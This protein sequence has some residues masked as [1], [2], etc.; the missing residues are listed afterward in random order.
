MSQ[1]YV[2]D[3]K[4]MK[5]KHRIAALIVTAASTMPMIA[6]A[7]DAPGADAPGAVAPSADAPRVVGRASHGGRQHRREFFHCAQGLAV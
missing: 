1:L 4:I 5:I 2:E 3:R 6:G 7:A